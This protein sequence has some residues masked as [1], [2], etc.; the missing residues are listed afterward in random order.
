MDE[1]NPKLKEIDAELFN[2]L[3]KR[4][5]LSKE[6]FSDDIL[7]KGTFLSKAMVQEFLDMAFK[8]FKEKANKCNLKHIVASGPVIIEDGKLLLSK[9]SK[10]DFYKLIGGTVKDGE[11][12]EE[13]CIRRAKEACGADIELIKPLWPNVL[14]ENPTTKEKMVIV[15]I[16]YLAKLNNKDYIKPIPPEQDVKWISIE[17]IK[18]GKGNAS[19]N[20]RVLIE[21][22]GL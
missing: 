7:S 10:D 16:N 22:N 6:R 13:A 20:V 9:D 4:F 19:P 12:L 1:M 15:L 21:K 3:N 5:E 11:E 8:E 18:Q 2:L 14:Y 17:D